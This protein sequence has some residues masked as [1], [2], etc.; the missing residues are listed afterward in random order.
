MLQETELWERLLI[1]HP[2]NILI[3]CPC[4][5]FEFCRDPPPW[6][7]N[8]GITTYSELKQRALNL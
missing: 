8:L 2:E 5:H 1:A 3:F 7:P 4:H 6:S